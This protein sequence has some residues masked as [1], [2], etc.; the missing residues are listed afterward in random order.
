MR[1]AWKEYL[2]NFNE[3]SMKDVVLTASMCLHVAF[4][5]ASLGKSLLA[6]LLTAA[7][8]PTTNEPSRAF[9]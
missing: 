6:L 1:L 3:I 9:T 8:L 4:N 5:L 2:E 7:L